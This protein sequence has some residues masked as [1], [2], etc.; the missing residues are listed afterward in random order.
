MK[1]LFYYES[2]NDKI[3]PQEIVLCGADEWESEAVCLIWNA[4]FYYQFNQHQKV[5]LSCY[6]TASKTRTETLRSVPL[7]GPWEEHKHINAQG[8][9]LSCGLG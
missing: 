7:T 4:T 5:N 2:N 8:S 3:I 9:C 1:Q 6:Y